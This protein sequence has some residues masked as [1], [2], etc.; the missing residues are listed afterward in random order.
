MRKI[1]TAPLLLL[2]QAYRYLVS[3]LLG[4]HCR[5]TPSCSEYALQAIAEHGPVNGTWLTLKRL[6]SCH[7]WHEGGYDPVP[8]NGREH[9]HG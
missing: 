4:N 8:G 3:P 1:L 6:G 7:P 2:I 5:Y 9:K